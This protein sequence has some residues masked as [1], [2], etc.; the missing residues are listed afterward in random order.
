[1]K[2]RVEESFTGLDIDLDERAVER[3]GVEG[4]GPFTVSRF[5]YGGVRLEHREL[6]AAEVAAVRET[7]SKFEPVTE[8]GRDDKARLLA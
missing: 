4:N 8:Q 6:T 3:G 7:V 5:G 2:I 1:M